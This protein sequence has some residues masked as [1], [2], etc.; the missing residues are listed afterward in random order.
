MRGE[1]FFSEKQAVL[2]RAY[3]EENES[4]EGNLPNLASQEYF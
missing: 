3:V 2:L 1:S 4:R